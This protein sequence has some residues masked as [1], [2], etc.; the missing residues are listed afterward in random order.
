MTPQYILKQSLCREPHCN[1]RGTREQ[2]IITALQEIENMGFAKSYAEP[3]Y[4]DPA[5]A[6]LFANWNY[7]PSKALELLEYYG[8]VCEWSDEWATCDNCYRAVRTEPDSWDYRPFFTLGD[9]EITCTH[10]LREAGEPLPD[11]ES[12]G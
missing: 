12:E 3:G 9:G 4:T 10:C 2:Q 7:L 1:S 6:V 5:K 11:E 8:Y